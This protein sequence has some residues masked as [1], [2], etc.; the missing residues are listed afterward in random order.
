[1][2]EILQKILAN[3]ILKQEIT[4]A[5][6]LAG[7]N[8]LEQAYAF[9]MSL[10]CLN[11]KENGDPCGVCLSCRKIKDGNH[12]DF[13]DIL[14]D[15]GFIRIEQTRSLINKLSL[16]KYEGK[17]KIALLHDCELLRDEAANN[18]L[19]TLEEPPDNTV[20]LLL[21]AQENK[22]LPTVRSRCRIV[23]LDYEEAEAFSDDEEKRVYLQSAYEF[24]QKLPS[25]PLYKVLA[26]SAAKDKDR[27]DAITFTCALTE[28]CLNSVKAGF[29]VEHEFI[30]FASPDDLLCCAEQ[31][32]KAEKQLRANVNI[33]ACLDMLFLRLWSLLKA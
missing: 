4:H 10:N 25:L 28:I 3:D 8:R 6:I 33:R 17:Y 19:K 5:Y 20:F 21:T 2:A 31:T 9:A 23:N 18:L 29:G 1:M 26:Q 15:R 14:P 16:E 13:F 27:D 12:P 11:R 30:I 7:A 24:L 22:I 32:Q